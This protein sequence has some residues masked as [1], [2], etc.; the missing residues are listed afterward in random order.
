MSA[1]ILQGVPVTTLD[2]DIWVDW[3]ERAYP[4]IH[5]LCRNLGANILAPTLVALS[6]DSLVN[7]LYRVDGL[8]SFSAEW[9]R[10]KWVRWQN[11]TVALLP[12]QSIIRSKEV[13]RRPKDIAHLELLKR[14]IRYKR[15]ARDKK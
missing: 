6:D 3:P 2:T 11:T 14:A 8:R 15:K 5:Q 13:V 7:F 10:A 1:A 9:K 4:R 12:L